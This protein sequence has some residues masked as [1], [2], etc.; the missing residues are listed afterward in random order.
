MISYYGLC[1]LPPDVLRAQ[2]MMNGLLLTILDT[3]LYLWQERLRRAEA[4]WQ[5]WLKFDE[6]EETLCKGEMR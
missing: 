5:D 4:R 1:T 6:H 3:D 2:R